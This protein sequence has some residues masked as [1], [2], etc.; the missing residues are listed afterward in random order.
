MIYFRLIDGIVEKYEIEV[1]IESL[2]KLREEVKYSCSKKEYIKTTGTRFWNN[3]EFIINFHSKPIGWIEYRDGPDERN[4]EYTYDRLIP[5]KLLKIIDGIIEGKLSSVIE[6]FEIDSSKDEFNFQSQI[7]S[8]L[9][10]ISSIPDTEINKK[11]NALNGLKDIYSSQEFN[12]NIKPTNEYYELVKLCI[13]FKKIGSIKVD[14]S[15]EV[16]NFFLNTKVNS[17]INNS[18]CDIIKLAK[19]MMQ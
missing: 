19:G 16:L 11:I 8:Q 15:N 2:K 10:Y 6:L 9:E 3:D 13:T 4:Y 7:A 14:V 18:T 12:K 1:D 17:Y 5:P